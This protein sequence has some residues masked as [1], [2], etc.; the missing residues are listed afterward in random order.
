MRHSYTCSGIRKCFDY[1]LNY[2]GSD[3]GY[4]F[5]ENRR[6]YPDAK[7]LAFAGGA[8]ENLLI[9]NLNSLN[10]IEKL[11]YQLSL[12]ILERLLPNDTRYPNNHR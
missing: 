3:N 4:H 10:Q 5:V 1:R 6:L 11:Y 9:A 2:C 7:P 8:E 12:L